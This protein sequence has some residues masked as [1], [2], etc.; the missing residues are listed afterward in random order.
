MLGGYTLTQRE[1]VT[2]KRRLTIAKK[3]GPE[4]VIAEC[5]HALSVFEDKGYPDSWHRWV[6]AR[7]DAELQ[8]RLNRSW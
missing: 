3:K 6:N 1:F 4:A 7:D 5:G 8:K 2:L